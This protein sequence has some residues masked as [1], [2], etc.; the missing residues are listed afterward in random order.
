MQYILSE[1]EYKN[2]VPKEKYYD[3]MD[4]VEKLNKKVL[5]LEYGEPTCPT[6]DSNSY[7]CDMCPISDFGTGTCLKVKKYSK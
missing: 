2:L 4:R 3:L 1:E 6:E 7:Y 5:E